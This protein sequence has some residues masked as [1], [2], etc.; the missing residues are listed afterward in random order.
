M[1][2]IPEQ[3]QVSIEWENPFALKVGQVFTGFGIGCGVGIGVGRPLNLGA[4][5][6]LQQ[7]TTAASGATD[8]FSGLGRHVTSSLRILGTKNIEAGIGC[9]VGFGHGFGVGLA[10]KPGVLHK[11][12]SCIAEALMR[13]ALKFGVVP[14][15]S[16]SQKMLPGSLKTTMN[17][18]NG[19]ILQSPMGNLFQAA[20]KLPEQTQGKLLDVIDV[21]S[22]QEPTT[23]KGT[24]SNALAGSRYEHVVSSFL[25]NPVLKDED[26][27]EVRKLV[28]RLDLENNILQMVLK[29]QQIIDEMVEENEKLR[30]VLIEELK[31]PP[32]KLQASKT[33]CIR[34]ISPCANCFECRR[35]LKKHK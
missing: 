14:G 13:I 18:M 17:A 12:H 1:E 24:S 34:S 4:I 6:A 35:R 11:L 10:I 16:S 23:S 28:G 2:G 20:R 27:F 26:D 31:V 22:K 15:L 8:A 3:K 9:G 29:H 30:H 21:E 33:S 25:K 32:N 5:P 7:V 19:T